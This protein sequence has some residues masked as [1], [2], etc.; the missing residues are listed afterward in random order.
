MATL[1]EAGARMKLQSDTLRRSATI[2]SLV[3]TLVVNALANLLPING[4]TTASISDSFPVLFVPAGYVFSIWGIIYIA[5]TAFTVYQALPSQRENRVLR[6]LGYLPALSGLVNSAWIFLWHYE[7]IPLTLVAML[8]LLGTLLAI[9]VKL[10]VGVT[11]ASRGIVW[12]AQ[13]P[14][15]IYLGWITVATIA[16]TTDLLYYLGWTGD[17][18]AAEVWA[19]LL[20]A[21]GA[22]ITAGILLTRGDIAYGL[23][24]I[25]AF[26]GIY[27]KQADTPVVANS[28][29]IGAGLVALLAV[30]SISLRTLRPGRR[31]GVSPA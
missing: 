1:V 30:A 19:V 2:G 22:L 28:A 8:T 3:I 10:G 16:N 11:P 14:F 20:L 17:G 9:Y 18:G 21:V 15:S 26:V 29:L 25:W 4:K 12:F 31:A 7:I 5:L 6:S 27:V 23:V 13:L 24:L